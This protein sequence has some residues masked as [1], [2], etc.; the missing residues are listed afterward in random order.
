MNKWVA[1]NRYWILLFLKD[2][3][4][5][6]ALQR[7]PHTLL[8]IKVWF[9]SLCCFLFFIISFK[10]LSTTPCLNWNWTYRI[11]YMRLYFCFTAI[12][13]F[14]SFLLF[15]FSLIASFMYVG[16]LAWSLGCSTGISWALELSSAVWKI[17][18]FSKFPC[19]M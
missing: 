13:F 2:E 12:H 9:V 19:R 3:T 15:S 6:I 4:L 16:A 14:L 18:A 5:C 8:L 7:K 11:K 17:F 10:Y 1:N